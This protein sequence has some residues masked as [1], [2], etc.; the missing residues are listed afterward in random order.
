MCPA[1]HKT[2]ITEYTVGVVAITAYYCSVPY[3]LFILIDQSGQSP[4]GACL[5]N[6]VA[7]NVIAGFAVVGVRDISNWA[8]T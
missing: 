8:G 2:L 5:D 6:A 1:V 3:G 4:A 7:V